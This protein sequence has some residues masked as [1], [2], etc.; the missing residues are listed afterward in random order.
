VDIS[1]AVDQV[2]GDDC[3][4][5]QHEQG[6]HRLAPPRRADEHPEQPDQA[7]QHALQGELAGKAAPQPGNLR[8]R[9][10]ADLQRAAERAAGHV[11]DEAR[12]G[13]VIEGEGLS[14]AEFDLVVGRGRGAQGDVQVKQQRREQTHQQQSQHAAAI[15]RAAVWRCNWT[16]C[17][18]D[19]DE[20]GRG[21]QQHRAV[22]RQAEA[23][24]RGD[25]ERPATA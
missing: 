14:G 8:L 18:Q 3:Q 10:R 5:S 9:L 7:E 13:G 21:Q 24:E 11:G 22:V 4:E 16:Q 15:D 1:D 23:V 19:E 12:N 2:E 6:R 20:H 17:L 25:L